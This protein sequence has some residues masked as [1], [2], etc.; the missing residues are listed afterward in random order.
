MTN[1]KD[2]LAKLEKATEQV[3]A[4]EDSKRKEDKSTTD[5]RILTLKKG[6]TYT[7]R[8]MLNLKDDLKNVD[9]S[10]ITY[11]E[12]AF[13]SPVT[14]EYVNG[15]RAPSDLRVK[16]DILTKTKWDEYKKA[17]E[18]G[19][20]KDQGGWKLLNT[21][22]KQLV[23]F[24]LHAVDGEDSAAKEKIGTIVVLRYPAQFNKDKKP[25]S[26]IYKV[27]SEAREDKKRFG[28]KIFDLTSR[29]RSLIIKV[30]EKAGYNNYS[31]TKFDDA[32]DLGLTLDQIG[33][34]HESVH[35]LNEFVPEVKSQD[36]IRALLDEFY[37]GKNANL[38]D[39][40][41]HDELPDDD[42]QLPGVESSDED[43]DALIDSIT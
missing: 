40:V 28:Q 32:E 43:T 4:T 15:G 18:A 29:G 35:D 2:L 24:Y 3:S 7:G 38:E 42:D 21:K 27:I 10:I 39:E 31:S 13:N 17:K 20:E 1:V 9:D 37:F 5:S 41:E 33:A 30:T 16:N 34:L 6:V 14:G 11:E 12:W 26:D 36:E 23:N 22:R 19:T 8:L 25:S